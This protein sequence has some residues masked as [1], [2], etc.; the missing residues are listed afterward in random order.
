MSDSTS[1][2][3]QKS[4]FIH[5][6]RWSEQYLKTDMVY[7]VQN[8]GWLFLGQIIATACAFITMLI[9]A[10]TMERADYGLY[11]FAI[12]IIIL[13]SSFT[14]PG[15][16]TSFMQATASGK[17]QSLAAAISF[18]I[19]WGYIAA[20]CSF[21]LSIYYFWQDNTTLSLMFFVASF[22]VCF[23]SVFHTSLSYL[24]GKKEFKTVATIQIITQ[25]ALLVFLSGAVFY[26][27][28]PVFLVV[29]YLFGS[30]FLQWLSYKFT[31]HNFA[32][33][34]GRLEQETISYGKHLTLYSTLPSL[35]LAQSGVIFVWF[36]LEAQE[37]ALY[38]I[39]MIIPIEISRFSGIFAQIALPKMSSQQTDAF[40]LLKKIIILTLIACIAWLLYALSAPAL[41]TLL[42]PE[43][44]DAILYST[45]AMGSV[46]FF[47]KNI[48]LSFFIAKKHNSTIRNVYTLTVI[49]QLLSL[50]LLVPSYG[51]V[52]AITAVLLASACEFLL[53]CAFLLQAR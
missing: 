40:A 16:A 1:E 4:K 25:A 46:V 31:S 34:S 21:A 53:L 52:G 36:F 18:R 22:G 5:F 45:L 51:I 42:L 33:E 50:L 48:L 27:V 47:S 17:Q 3:Q 30:V 23:F 15:L 20:M 29:V 26:S 9:L 12:A 37:A 41:F 8:F 10:N 32:T 28:N 2:S 7:L 44:L 19:R 39:A 43:Y 14:L 35:I 6:L 49:I 38:S 24:Q 11:R 13:L